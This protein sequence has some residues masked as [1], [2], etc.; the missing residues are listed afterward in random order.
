MPKAKELAEQIL[1]KR[2]P[3][4]AI[5]RNRMYLYE[6]MKTKFGIE[7]DTEMTEEEFRQYLQEVE[8]HQG[9]EE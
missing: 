5:L 4:G 7:D 6:A 2:T 9:G 1:I 8:G 3:K